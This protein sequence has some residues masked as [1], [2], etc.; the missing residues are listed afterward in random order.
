MKIS[1]KEN[2]IA[3]QLNKILIFSLALEE[4]LHGQKML[5][6]PYKLYSIKKEREFIVWNLRSF[7]CL[8]V[9]QQDEY[10]NL[11]ISV[12]KACLFVWSDNK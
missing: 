1:R 6:N 11:L 2:W 10:F 5:E 7:G 12:W 4:K 8:I 3:T 9:N